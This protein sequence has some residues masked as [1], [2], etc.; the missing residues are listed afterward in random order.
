[1]VVV[2]HEFL[3]DREA[4]GG[5][6]QPTDSEA[7]LIDRFDEALDFAVDFRRVGSE[8]SMKDR[9]TLKIEGLALLPASGKTPVCGLRGRRGFGKIG[10]SSTLALPMSKG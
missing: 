6:A 3:P 9:T 10:S 4:G 7:L 2:P 1:M 8:P 5:G